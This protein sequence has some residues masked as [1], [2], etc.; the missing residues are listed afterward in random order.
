MFSARATSH[1]SPKPASLLP[2]GATEKLAPKVPPHPRTSALPT[3]AADAAG[4]PPPPSSPRSV[5]AA[6]ATFRP[7]A[8]LSSG[9]PQ[10]TQPVTPSTAPPCN[11]DPTSRHGDSHRRR[12]LHA[13]AAPPSFGSGP[14]G[15]AGAAE[16]GGGVGQPSY[17]HRQAHAR[18]RRQMGD[19]VME[20]GTTMVSE[21][22]KKKEGEGGGGEKDRRGW[23]SGGADSPRREIRRKKN[24]QP[25]KRKKTWTRACTW[26]AGA[27]TKKGRKRVS[28]CWTTPRTCLHTSGTPF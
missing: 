21:N 22:A 20:R 8:S 4:A 16:A 15:H 9:R 5:L 28:S 1:P 6:E 12:K 2:P 10:P 23:R 18:P 25:E 27:A 17:T 7:Q 13:C 3:M 11:R 24:R 26:E 19:S 14:H